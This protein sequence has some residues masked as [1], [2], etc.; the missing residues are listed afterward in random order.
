MIAITVRTLLHAALG[1]GVVLAA[2]P[3]ARAVGPQ[4]TYSD[5]WL[6]D[7]PAEGFFN[8]DGYI[9]PLNEPTV[10]PGQVPFA[11]FYSSQFGIVTGDGGY[12]GIQKDA[13]GKRAIFSIWGASAANCADVP[14]AICRPFT[15]EG[16][17]YQTMVPYAWVPG[18]RY[19]TR[20]WVQ[21]SD[22]DG[23]WWVGELG[24]VTAGTA[25]VVGYIR[26]PHAYQW[27]KSY[28]IN[29]V[30]W[31]A[32][33][34]ASCDQLPESTVLFRTAGRQRRWRP[35][36]RAEQPLRHRC[37]PVEHRHA[38]RLGAASQWRPRPPLRRRLR[39]LKALATDVF[40]APPFSTPRPGAAAVPARA[41]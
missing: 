21:G 13:N 30:E 4:G 33:Q 37:V 26:V 14:G 10:G 29:W 2:V 32:P 17:G 36:G 6:P 24:D 39:A 12:I 3:Q 34:A 11:Y 1:A 41:R 5:W 7:Q 35:R 16:D 23:D 40:E 22:A 27:L 15:G 19:R 25:E 9:Q 18:H 28:V 8:L 31:Y 38:Q 20:V